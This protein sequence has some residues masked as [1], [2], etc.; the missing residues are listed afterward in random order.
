MADSISLEASTFKLLRPKAFLSRFLAENIRPDG[1]S[2]HSFRSTAVTTGS[3]STADGSALVR[4]GDSTV[5]C[6][7]RVEIAEPD[8]LRPNQGF[9]VP[10]IDLSPL[11][12]ARFRPGPPSDEAQVLSHRLRTIVLSASTV[13][14]KS[15]CIKPG[16][17]AWV[18]YVDAIC[19][20]FDG[21]L[22]DATVLAVVAALKDARLPAVR[23]NEDENLVE[24]VTEQAKIPLQV[25]TPIYSFSF[26]IFEQCCLLADPDAFEETL[27]TSFITIVVDSQGKLRHFWQAGFTS[28]DSA[29]SRTCATQCLALARQRLP[30]LKDM[31]H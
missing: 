29:N 16:K 14:L 12:S 11:C 20:N 22:I 8:I 18:V 21:N 26:G 4:M 24:R 6:G 27:C 19:I 31:L 30:A 2:F 13:P 9:I 15:L 25:Q 17:S 1:R 7:I 28:I 3:I 10:N 5:V 23:W